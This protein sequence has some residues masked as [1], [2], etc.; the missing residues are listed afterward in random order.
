MNLCVQMLIIAKAVLNFKPRSCF[1]NFKSSVL[2]KTAIFRASNCGQKTEPEFALLVL[3]SE[4][5][6]YSN[7][8][9]Q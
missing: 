9:L 3:K 7:L 1:F 2:S 4:F 8:G 5:T 6:F